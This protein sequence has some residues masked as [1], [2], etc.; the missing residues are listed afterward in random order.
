MRLSI[1]PEKFRQPSNEPHY[2]NHHRT[3]S[4]SDN[5]GKANLSNFRNLTIRHNQMWQLY[6]RK[7]HHIP[8]AKT[9]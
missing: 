9:Q 7:D 3:I 1:W 6:K 5:R 4:N 8:E 2:N